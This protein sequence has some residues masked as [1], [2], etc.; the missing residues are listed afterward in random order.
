VPPIAAAPGIKLRGG[1]HHMEY[2][3]NY[4]LYYI[5]LTDFLGTTDGRMNETREVFNSALW[6]SIT[7]T[8]LPAGLRLANIPEWQ[9]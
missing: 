7:Q 3:K 2:L 5:A 6:V 8:Y 4:P 1:A 9:N